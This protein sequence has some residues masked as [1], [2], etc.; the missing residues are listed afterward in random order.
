[1]SGAGLATQEPLVG[2]WSAASGFEAGR[3]IA[4]DTGVTA[5]FAGND[6]MALGVLHALHEA[7]RRVPDD[8][9][10]VG[11]D[12]IPEAAFLTPALTTVHQDFADVGARA[13]TVLMAAIHGE[14]ATPVPLLSPPLVIR[15]STAAHPGGH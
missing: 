9:S 10:V 5:V 13:I 14:S 8:V 1:M 12:D 2:D 4:T 7:G 11:F 15:G 3:A 6:Q